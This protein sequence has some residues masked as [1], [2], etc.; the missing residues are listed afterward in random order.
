MYIHEAIQAMTMEKPCIARR[1][2]GRWNKGL[3]SSG[4]RIQPT[5]SPDCC[6]IESDAASFHL[7]GWQPTKDDL[8]ADDWEPVRL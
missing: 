8:V 5:N 6:I 4:V 2:W 3:P 7:R 1:S